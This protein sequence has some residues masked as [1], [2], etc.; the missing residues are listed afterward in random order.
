MMS[1]VDEPLEKLQGMAAEMKNWRDIF[2]QTLTL[3]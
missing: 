3:K 1:V 2:H